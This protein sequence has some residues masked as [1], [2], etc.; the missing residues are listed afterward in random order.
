[1][2]AVDRPCFLGAWATRQ[3]FGPAPTTALVISKERRRPT[4]NA[5]SRVRELS[6]VGASMHASM[7]R[8]R[9]SVTLYFE[10]EATLYARG[11][12]GVPESSGIGSNLKR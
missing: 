1:M 12:R 3:H 4:H 2:S 11:P 8:P 10:S 9:S 6:A 5:V 7:R